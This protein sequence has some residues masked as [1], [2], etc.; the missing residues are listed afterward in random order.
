MVQQFTSDGNLRRRSRNASPTGDMHSTQCRFCGTLH[1][2]LE[3]LRRR[4]RPVD[5][6]RL[7]AQD[8]R[9][10]YL[11]DLVLG[12]QVRHLARVEDVVDVLQE[13]LHLDLRVGE[14]EHRGVALAPALR[15]T[16]FRS[17]RHSNACRSDLEI[18][19]WN[20]SYSAMNAAMRVR[21]WRP[22]P[23]TP[24]SSALPSSCRMTREMRQMC[25]AA[26]RNS[27]RSMRV[28]ETAGCKSTSCSSTTLEQLRPSP[29]PRRTP[30]S[31]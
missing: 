15:S 6:R 24:T 23:P 7:G 14:E 25:S 3:L 17:S 22:E 27:T 29:S 21:L 19:I 9:L 8:D 30:W 10:D 31:S 12:E 11:R 4:T 16:I 28:L 20:T 2:K 1:E 5:P 13:R 18:S 26:Y